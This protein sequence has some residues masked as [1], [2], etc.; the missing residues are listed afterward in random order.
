MVAGLADGRDAVPAPGPQHLLKMPHIDH[1]HLRVV[2]LLKG[3]VKSI[4]VAAQQSHTFP[5]VQWSAWSIA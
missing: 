1:G 4:A 5:L 2:R 3:A